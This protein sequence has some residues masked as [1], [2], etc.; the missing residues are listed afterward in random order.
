MF[1]QPPSWQVLGTLSPEV[2]QSRHENDH[3]PPSCVKISGRGNKL[4]AGAILPFC[5]VTPDLPFCVQQERNIYNHC[6]ENIKAYNFTFA[7]SRGNSTNAVRCA[8]RIVI[9]TTLCYYE[10]SS[11]TQSWPSPVASHSCGGSGIHL[12]KYQTINVTSDLSVVSTVQSIRGSSIE[13]EP[14][15]SFRAEWLLYVPPTLSY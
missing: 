13:F 10:R 6:S 14:T 2:N 5:D 9:Q 11:W 7:F 12:I 8:S 3:S 1:T 15:Y 4:N